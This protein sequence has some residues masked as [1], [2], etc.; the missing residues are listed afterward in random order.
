VES[1]PSVCR[2][3]SPIDGANNG[4][5][6]ESVWETVD[7]LRKPFRNMGKQCRRQMLPVLKLLTRYCSS[8]P[9]I[10]SC[11][12]CSGSFL[13]RLEPHQLPAQTPIRNIGRVQ[14]DDRLQM[15]PNCLSGM[16]VRQTEQESI[17]RVRK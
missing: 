13:F 8:S 6:R 16:S 9:L 14:L 4:W 10:K 1:Q 2:N 17:D 11:F 12:S 7:S 3:Q 5:N 15:L